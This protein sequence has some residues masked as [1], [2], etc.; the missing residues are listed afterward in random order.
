MFDGLLARRFLF[1][2]NFQALFLVFQPLAVI[3]LKRNALA[4]VQFQNPAG[5]VVQEVAVVGD[6][7]HCAGVVVQEAFQPGYRFGIQMVGGLVQQQHVRAGQQQTAQR[8]AAALTAGEVFHHGVPGR[9]AK[10]IG[11]HFH[12]ALNIVAVGSLYKGFQF[13]LFLGEGIKVGIRLGIG[14]IDLIQ[15]RQCVMD[16]RDRLIDDFL[17]GLG[18][19]QFRFLGQVA[20]VDAGL[21]AGLT[22]VILV[23]TGHNT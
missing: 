11:S 15:L 10:G 23:D 20:D 22:N 12:L 13:A 3:A 16:A 19:V 1:G 17:D 6:G 5:H 8:H 9:Q 14:G 21:G 4:A 7:N 2:F 18:V